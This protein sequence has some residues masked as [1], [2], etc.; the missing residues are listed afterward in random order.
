MFIISV[1]SVSFIV[2]DLENPS[3]VTDGIPT[4]LRTY[5]PIVA[6]VV[7]EYVHLPKKLSGNCGY[8]SLHLLDN[9][10]ILSSAACTSFGNPIRK[11]NILSSCTC[12]LP[13]R[14]CMSMCCIASSLAAIISFC[15]LDSI[16][17]HHSE[18]LVLAFLSSHLYVELLLI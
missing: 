13:P 14:T 12:C 6:P 15:T 10:S 16:S 11:S 17:E 18:R 1:F 8:C 5:P 3:Q 2:S 9:C 7:F 4:I